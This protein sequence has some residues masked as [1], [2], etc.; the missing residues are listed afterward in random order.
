MAIPSIRLALPCCAHSGEEQTQGSLIFRITAVGLGGI[1]LLIGILALSGIHGINA[2]GTV[3]GTALTIT[4]SLVLLAGLCLRCIKGDGIEATAPRGTQ[5]SHVPTTQQP[6]TPPK[7]QL[8]DRRRF[9]LVPPYPFTTL[10]DTA[11]FAAI[12]ADPTS[13]YPQCIAPRCFYLHWDGLTKGGRAVVIKDEN[14]T[15]KCTSFLA[16]ITANQL[17]A[18]LEDLG[19]HNLSQLEH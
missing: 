4:G 19:W 16:D 9:P 10:F 8:P 12:N 18:Y 7:T 11:D 13:Q 3:G 1:A 6:T 17:C 15:W 2:L 14:G 5:D